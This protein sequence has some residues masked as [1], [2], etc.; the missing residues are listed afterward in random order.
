MGFFEE[1][2]LKRR[3]KAG[4]QYIDDLVMALHIKGDL[5]H[6]NISRVGVYGVIRDGHKMLLVV[7]ATG[8]YLNRFDLPGGGIE[9]GET[10]SQALHR[11][12][13]EE[14]GMDFKSMEPITNLTAKVEM[15]SK[16]GWPSYTF[17]QIGLIY[18]VDGLHALG[19][20]QKGS[21]HHEWVD[22]RTLHKETVSPFAWEII[23]ANLSSIGENA[24]TK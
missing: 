5:P 18:S 7:Q 10:I 4:D 1:G 20:N 8:T 12:F 19:T 21:L 2:C 11:E 6:R 14:V 3:V 17:H 24:C 23:Q 22:I 9:F 15:P 13:L 16:E